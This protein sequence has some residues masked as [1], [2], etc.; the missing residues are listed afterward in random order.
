MC[1]WQGL[2]A[3]TNDAVSPLINLKVLSFQNPQMCLGTTRM[4]ERTE[5]FE[6]FSLVRGP[7]LVDV[8]MFPRVSL[9]MQRDSVT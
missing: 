2:S 6:V 8:E 7:A 5:R 3:H 9:K 4:S 1:E